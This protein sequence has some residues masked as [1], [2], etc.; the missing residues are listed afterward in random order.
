MR[1]R[2][3]ISAAVVTGGWLAAC[4]KPASQTA[5][6]G[7]RQI[8]LAEP[9]SPDSAVVSDLES[10]HAL[11]PVLV[12]HTDHARAEP[13]QQAF[14]TRAAVVAAQVPEPH[15][16]I[17]TASPGAEAPLAAGPS[18]APE[19]RATGFGGP[20]GHGLGSFQLPPPEPQSLSGGGNRGPMILIRGGM[21]GIDDKCDTR[22]G[23]R[24]GIAINRLSPAFG[25]NPRGGIR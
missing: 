24:G 8:Q 11:Q 7:S 4:S 14:Q 22:T 3:L 17:M 9:S 10:H 13:G 2:I 20:I 18:A 15:V 25:G 5:Q 12:R 21:G 6:G 1:V 16:M 23:H 19:A